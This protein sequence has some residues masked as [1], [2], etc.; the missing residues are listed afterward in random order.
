M[1]NGELVYR[2]PETDEIESLVGKVFTARCREVWDSGGM[3][4]AAFLRWRP[5]KTPEMCDGVVTLVDM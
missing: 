1:L 4:G 5:D 3:R 2:N